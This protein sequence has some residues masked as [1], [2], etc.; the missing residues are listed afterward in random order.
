MRSVEY[1]YNLFEKLGDKKCALCSCKIPQII[2]GAHIWPVADIKC[3]EVLSLDEKLEIALD[4]D[5]GLWLCHNHHKLLDANIL[6]ISA[7]GIVKYSSEI[8]EINAK[9]L[10]S[11]TVQTRLHGAI[12]T[13]KFTYYLTKRNQKIAEELYR[14]IL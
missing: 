1:I 9:F 14:E 4:G 3:D 12:L 7:D 8:N 10:K 2:Q 13:D 6:R 11:I 5:N